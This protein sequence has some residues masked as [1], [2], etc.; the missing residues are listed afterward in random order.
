MGVLHLGQKRD[1][2]GAG[3]LQLGQNIANAV[4]KLI[5]VEPSLKSVSA[6]TNAS[7]RSGDFLAVA[8]MYSNCWHSSSYSPDDAAPEIGRAHV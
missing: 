5:V 8:G 6:Q 3:N 4:K 7:S 2:F 1:D